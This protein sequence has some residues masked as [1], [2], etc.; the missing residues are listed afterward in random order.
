MRLFT[1]NFK[2][3]LKVIVL[4]V[5]FVAV[6]YSI[7]LSVFKRTWR[8]KENLYYFYQLENNSLDVINIG[9]SHVHSGINTIQLYR[10]EGIASYNLSA[11]SQPVWYSWYYLREAMKTQNPK[12]VVLDVYTLINPDDDAFIE[13]AQLNLLTMKP[14]WN[15]LEALYTSGTDQVIRLFLGFPKNHIRYREL[16]REK[17][18]GI[19]L[20]N[21]PWPHIS[22]EDAKKYNYI[23]GIAAEYGVDFLNGC[24]LEEEL[25]I[26]YS[27]DNGGDYGH[28]NYMGSLKWTRY[29]GDYLSANY[30]LPD[31]RQA[32]ERIWEESARALENRMTEEY[33]QKVNHPSDYLEYLQEHQEYAFALIFDAPAPPETGRLLNELEAGLGEAENGY[34]VRMPDGKLFTGKNFPGDTKLYADLYDNIRGYHGKGEEYE[35][36]LMQFNSRI[37][38]SRKKEGIFFIVFDPFRTSPLDMIEFEEAKGYE[39]VTE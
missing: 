30:D 14:S 7:L 34:L 27:T 25:G 38:E 23:G 33:L 20:V 32:P 11:G 28:L 26:D 18:M 39:R 12:V 15:K 35:F 16:C 19:V 8:P 31:R 13:K 24:A 6:L 29:L 37:A 2:K 22:V 10:E 17:D 21:A 4:S 36:L 3:P 9:S 1:F 5:V